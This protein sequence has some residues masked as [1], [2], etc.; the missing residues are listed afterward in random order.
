MSMHPS[1]MSYHLAT[2]ARLLQAY[3][4]R[5]EELQQLAFVRA[6]N[7]SYGHSSIVICL[8]EALVS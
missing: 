5:G 6:A 3:F 1:L 4:M 8:A 7:L 2:T